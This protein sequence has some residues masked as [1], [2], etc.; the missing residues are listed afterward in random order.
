LDDVTPK[1]PSSLKLPWKKNNI[2]KH[3]HDVVLSRSILR[4]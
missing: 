2:L 3:R 4:G 1:G